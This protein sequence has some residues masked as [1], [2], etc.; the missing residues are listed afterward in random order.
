MSKC[1]REPLDVRKKV[2]DSLHGT[3]SQLK[4]IK[5][6]IKTHKNYVN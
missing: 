4:Q 6:F 2:L 5:L 3:E 1:I